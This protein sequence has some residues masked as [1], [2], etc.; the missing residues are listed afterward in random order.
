MAGTDGRDLS[1]ACVRTQC[2]RRISVG[3]LLIGGA[4]GALG[5]VVMRIN[6]TRA[7]Y[8]QMWASLTPG[9]ARLL[10]GYLL[11]QAAVVEQLGDGFASGPQS[12]HPAAR[13]RASRVRL[14]AGRRPS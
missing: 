10:A 6:C 4:A 1:R 11:T 14:L 7:E 5:R 9:E 3:R 2:G 8:D 13:A 12:S